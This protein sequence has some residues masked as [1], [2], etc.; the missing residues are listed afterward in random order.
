MSNYSGAPV[1]VRQRCAAGGRFDGT[2]P[3]AVPVDAD[4]VRSYAPE[5]VQKGGLFRAGASVSLL[6]VE[7]PQPWGLGEDYRVIEQMIVDMS[8]LPGANTWQV[9]IVSA[10][11][12]RTVWRSGVG[13]A[14]LV[15]NGDDEMLLL[16]PDQWLEASMNGVA[17]GACLIEIWNRRHGVYGSSSRA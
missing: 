14:V 4:G 12:D 13:G 8:G 17:A 11:G 2:L 3:T 15:V 1:V 9:E 7:H 5:T 6:G 10:A 16:T